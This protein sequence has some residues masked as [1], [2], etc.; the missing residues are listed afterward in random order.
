MFELME[1]TVRLQLDKILSLYVG[2]QVLQLSMLVKYVR[3]S[4]STKRR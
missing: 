3:P 4:A 2:M 1:Q